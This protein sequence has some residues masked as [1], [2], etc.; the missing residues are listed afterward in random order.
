MADNAFSIVLLLGGIAA[1]CY[2]AFPFLP[3]PFAV[4]S[5]VAV[6]GASELGDV[7]QGCES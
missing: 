5:V 6:L 2:F 4:A 1:A 7:L 3:I